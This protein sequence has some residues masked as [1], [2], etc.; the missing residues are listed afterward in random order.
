MRLKEGNKEKDILDA[1]VRIFA[2]SGYHKA[3]ISKVAEDAGVAT[4]SVYVYFKSKED[5]LL[6]I[7]SNLWNKLYDELDIV[8]K[9]SS[10]SSSEKLDS[11]IDLLFDVFTEKPALALVYVNEQNH[12]ERSIKNGFTHYYSK[13]L[14][15]GEKII[16]SGIKDGLFSE[17]VDITIFRH[18]VFGA[19][20]H[21]VHCWAGDPSTFPLSKTRLNVKLLIKRGIEK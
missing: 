9:N 12:L 14:D 13:F 20:R 4:G 21:L 3:K 1:A 7:F 6:K 18:F 11:M 8:V 19:I 15:E 2:K 10:L 5:I 16:E 17:H